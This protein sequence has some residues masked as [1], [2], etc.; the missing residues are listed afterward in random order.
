MHPSV[1]FRPTTTASSP[2]A[3]KSYPITA[4]QA[5][6]A[7]KAWIESGC[8]NGTNGLQGLIAEVTGIARADCLTASDNLSRKLSRA[9][10]VSSDPRTRKWKVEH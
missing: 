5:E 2:G 1:K 4:E 7:S 6:A 8:K 3:A 10:C 9:G